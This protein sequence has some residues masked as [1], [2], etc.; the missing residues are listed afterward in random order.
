MSAM[1]GALGVKLEKTGQYTIGET[2][3]TLKT[4]HVCRALRIMKTT[5]AVFTLLVAVPL[6]YYGSQ[7]I[8]KL[9]V[10]I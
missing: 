7:L 1:A 6:D 8:Q 3:E 5:C 10:R 2:Y 9:V 4:H